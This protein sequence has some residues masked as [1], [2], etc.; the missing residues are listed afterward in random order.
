MNKNELKPARVFEQFAKIN[1]I[2]RPSKHEEKMIAY[3]ETFAKEHHLE[4]KVDET[5][6]VLIKKAATPGYENKPVT[7]LQSHMDMVCDKLVD[8]DFNF[9]TDPIQT[10]IEDPLAVGFIKNDVKE[11]KTYTL[12]VDE[13][14]DKIIIKE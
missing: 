5:G 12:D 14:E 3:L 1:E 9:H 13:K 6:N 11:N 4:Y 10:Y 8:V 2:P 7:I